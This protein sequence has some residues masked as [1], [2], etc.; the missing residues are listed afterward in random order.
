MYRLHLPIIGCLFAALFAADAAAADLH[1]QVLAAQRAHHAAVSRQVSPRIA[2]PVIAPAPR[3]PAHPA[4]YT[5]GG[6]ACQGVTFPG[7]EHGRNAT[8]GATR[9]YDV[10]GRPF[11]VP[12][13]RYLVRYD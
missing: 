11:L 1:E 8:F 6:R 7:R 4:R 9:C 2:Q 5:I 13:S 10:H 12:G 3:A